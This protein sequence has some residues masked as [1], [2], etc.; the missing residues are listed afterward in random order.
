MREKE[1]ENDNK[2]LMLNYRRQNKENYQE[3]ITAF[4]VEN[5]SFNSQILNVVNC[6]DNLLK[7]SHF[8]NSNQECG[9]FK[10]TQSFINCLIN[11]L[12]Y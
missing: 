7:V 3:K 8:C 10:F 1:I 11:Q 5:M 2:K 6:E 9:V 4:I 12:G